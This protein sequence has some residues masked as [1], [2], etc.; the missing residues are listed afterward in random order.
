MS[1]EKKETKLDVL[2]EGLYETLK[3]T[4]GFV[5]EQAPDVAKEMIAER[6]VELKYDLIE[7]IVGVSVGLILMLVS[8]LI[9]L[10]SNW[11]YVAACFLRGLGLLFGSIILIISGETTMNT[12]SLIAQLKSAP[13]VFILYRLRRLM[14]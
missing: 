12:L 10:P 14:K 3:E 8:Y 13:K 5:L 1:E 7:N 2:L 4:K 6:T 9:D 11:D